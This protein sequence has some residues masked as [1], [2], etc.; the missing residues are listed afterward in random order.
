M[1]HNI[2]FDGRVQS[3]RLN[4]E[5]GDATIGVITKGRC[6][7]SAE[8]EEHVSGQLR[9]RLPGRE[10]KVVRTGEKYAVPRSSSFDVEALSDAAY[11]CYYK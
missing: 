5:E 11:I 7:F 9:V 8:S 3:L 4:M 10:W 6:T 2:Y 1:K